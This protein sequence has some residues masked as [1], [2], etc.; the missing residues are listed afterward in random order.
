[1]DGRTFDGG[2]LR[3]LALCGS[4][5]AARGVLARYPVGAEVEGRYDPARPEVAYLEH[6]LHWSGP[7]LAAVGTLLL[8]GA[9][10]AGWR[11]LRHL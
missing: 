11:A 8:V 5:T 2:T 1:V 9:C 6:D 3:A 10:V 7:A 4:E